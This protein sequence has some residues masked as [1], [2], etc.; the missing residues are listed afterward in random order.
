[1]DLASD[2]E[3]AIDLPGLMEPAALKLL[4]KLTGAEETESSI[5]HCRTIVQRL[6]Y[7]PLAITQAGSYIKKRQVPL[8]QFIDEFN[9]RKKQILEHTPKLTEYRRSLD[10]SQQETSL[11]VF[12]TWELSFEQLLRSS[13]G[14]NQSSLLTLFAFFDGN[15][16]SEQLFRVY[17]KVARKH[18][19]HFLWPVPYLEIYLDDESKW[20]SY[21][22]CDTLVNLTGLSL[23]QSWHRGEGDFCHCSLHP[24]VQDWIRLRTGPEDFQISVCIAAKILEAI[25]GV[26]WDDWG[27][28]LELAVRQSLMS[29][30][31]M[32]IENKRIV[33]AKKEEQPP[34]QE[35]FLFDNRFF[36]TENMIGVFLNSTGQYN[37]ALSMQSRLVLS[38]ERVLGPENSTKL[39][40]M[41]NLAYS[42]SIVG[43]YELAEQ[44]FRQVRESWERNLGPDHPD[45]ITSIHNLTV[46][47]SNTGNY[48]AA[49]NMI[50]R[51]SVKREELFGLKHRDT[52]TSLQILAKNLEFQNKL[53]EAEPIARQVLEG[54]EKLLGPEAIETLGGATTLGSILSCQARLH[55]AESMTRRALVGMERKLG[56]E[57][58]ETLGILSDL[59][60]ILGG[61][62]KVEAAEEML[63]RALETSQKLLGREDKTTLHIV[64]NLAEFEKQWEEYTRADALYQ[65]VYAG[66]QKMLGAEHPKTIDVAKDYARVL[67]KMEERTENASSSEGTTTSGSE[68]E[69][70]HND[71]ASGGLG[72]DLAYADL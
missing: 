66:F 44:I 18:P 71:S 21:E 7:H 32:Y 40:Y 36:G 27:F 70:D 35:S 63:L 19:Y 37:E 14:S 20:N 6:G 50:R 30:A 28:D 8:H 12:T 53:E 13:S 55:D 65:R 61:Q 51:V 16:I 46:A 67:E 43:K 60:C 68:D 3:S 54:Y 45:T 59:G 17:C 58:P 39:D 34:E 24:L 4:F 2:A 38:V 42:Y 25:L 47:I 23:L 72:D 5:P 22:F 69:E 48:E 33:D 62:G 11:N 26:F 1:M 10:D 9:R 64:W 41:S 52:L 31:S 29:H 49:E 57:A 15:D 56:K